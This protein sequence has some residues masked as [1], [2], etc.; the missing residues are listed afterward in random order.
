MSIQEARLVALARVTDP[1]RVQEAA[2]V[3]LGRINASHND[4]RLATEALARMER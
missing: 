3:L 1:F 4:I 2:Q